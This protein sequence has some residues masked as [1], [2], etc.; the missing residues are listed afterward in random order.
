MAL[1]FYLVTRHT[2][3]VGDCKLPAHACITCT[4]CWEQVESKLR[5]GREVTWYFFL[6]TD[7]IISPKPL[8]FHIMYS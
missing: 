6:E 7:D 1:F 5:P 8:L 4:F 2:K 3:I